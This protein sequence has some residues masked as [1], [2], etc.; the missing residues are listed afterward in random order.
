MDRNNTCRRKYYLD[1]KDVNNL[2][3]NHIQLGYFFENRY[4][5]DES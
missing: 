3:D 2:L 4:F 5:C 1:N